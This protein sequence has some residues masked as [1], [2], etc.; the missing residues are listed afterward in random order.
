MTLCNRN[1]CS[2]Y[3]IMKL[4]PDQLGNFLYYTQVINESQNLNFILR[5]FQVWLYTI[6]I[7]L[8]RFYCLFI[9]S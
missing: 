9:C 7:Y 6:Y 8:Q 2:H 4:K 5:D 3:R 1:H